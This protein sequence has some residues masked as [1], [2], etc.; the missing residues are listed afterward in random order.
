[1]IFFFGNNISYHQ[2]G[3]AY[4]E[5]NIAPRENGNDFNS[6]GV[7]GNIDEPIRL[8]NNA[9]A[10]SFRIAALSRAGGEEIEVGKHCGHIS[11]TMNLLTE[12]HGDLPS[13]VDKID[14]CQNGIKVHHYIRYLS[15]MMKKWL[16]EE[17]SNAFDALSRYLVFVKQS[18]RLRNI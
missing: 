7:D 18:K 11:T 4:I 9:F 16:I 6:L 1:M 14:E 10:F 15:I 17:K 2:R 8:L 5:L 3:N 13:Y 12:K